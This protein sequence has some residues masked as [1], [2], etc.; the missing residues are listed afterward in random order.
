[1]I[2]SPP[3]IKKGFVAKQGQQYKTWRSRW[4]VLEEGFLTYYEKEQPTHPFGSGEKGKINLHH[5]VCKE[6]GSVV[7]VTSD[8]KGDR[9][10][11]LDIPMQNK[12]KEWIH[13]IRSHAQYYFP[14]KEEDSKNP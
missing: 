10:L 1:L 9:D 13:A 8:G 3:E 5:M 7:T 4:F 11:V 6:K 14:D 2:T 12:R